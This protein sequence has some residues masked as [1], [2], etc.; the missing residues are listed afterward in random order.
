M[1]FVKVPVIPIFMSAFLSQCSV[2]NPQT[3][4][5][6]VIGGRPAGD[7]KFMAAV[8]SAPGNQPFCGG[9]FIRP[10]VVMT[11]AHCVYQ[12]H[13]TFWIGVDVRRQSA[14]DEQHKVPVNA[15][16]VHPQYDPGEL[17][18]DIALLFL[19]RGVMNERGIQAEPIV[20]DD[21]SATQPGEL[22]RAIGWGNATSEGR[23]EEDELQ[24]VDLP[25]IP[26]NV[27]RGGGDDYATIQD[28][29][30]CAGDFTV[31]G[32]DT[33]YGDSGGPLFRTLGGVPRISGIVS[34]GEGCAEP[35]KPGVYTRVA[36]FRDWVDATMRR[37]DTL[38]VDSDA[39]GLA[40]AIQTF[41]YQGFSVEDDVQDGDNFLTAAQRLE[42]SGGFTR[43]VD[44][45]ALATVES[46][47]DCAFTLPSGRAFVARVL[48]QRSARPY[49]AVTSEG[50]AWQGALRPSLTLDMNC[51]GQGAEAILAFSQEDGYG[52]FYHGDDAFKFA[53]NTPAN[54]PPSAVE[55]SGCALGATSYQ[56]LT[57]Q[58]GDQS[59]TF[60]Q[61]TSDLLPDS[62]QTRE[63]F[64]FTPGT[65]EHEDAPFAVG[66][67]MAT[68]TAGQIAVINHLAKKVFGWQL[69]CN[70]AFTLRD[71]DGALFPSAPLDGLNRVQFSAADT[72]RGILPAIGSLVFQLTSDE[73]LDPSD[74]A[75]QCRLNGY[76]VNLARARD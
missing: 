32:R 4:D 58:D 27:C 12:T 22:L 71:E 8:G 49:L 28:T 38:A 60:L 47:T 18:N 56:Y 75:K 46:R 72:A 61:L 33:C 24:E 20:M 41:C 13:E 37:Y 69:A 36:S 40:T 31:G 26:N 2:P 53:A 55:Q 10:D 23:Y 73:A 7:Y 44:P 34:W 59:R 25:V 62:P 66:L 64:P 67:S 39:T 1:R 52:R 29:Q 50:E 6:K 21:G 15:V 16:I 48:G 19:D 65:P 76:K 30:I 9:S 43:L 3:S 68:E 45:L 57:A 54:L 17:R 74:P 42:P 11:A 35:G 70:F 5:V 63:L 51:R 14:I